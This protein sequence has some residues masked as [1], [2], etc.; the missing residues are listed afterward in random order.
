MCICFPL[1]LHAC[2]NLDLDSCHAVRTA[3]RAKERPGFSSGYIR[4][5]I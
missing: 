5:R 2:Y 3:F 4:S 1:C